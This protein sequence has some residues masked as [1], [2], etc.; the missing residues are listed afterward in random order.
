[1]RRPNYGADGEHRDVRQ[2]A[3]DLLRA[4]ALGRAGVARAR[5]GG[6][7]KVPEALILPLSRQE[8]LAGRQGFEPRYADPESAVLPLDDLPVRRAL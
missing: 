6:P 5:P 1:M 7:C 8:S 2:V 4:Q 3:R